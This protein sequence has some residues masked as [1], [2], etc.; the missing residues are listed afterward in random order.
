MA[1]QI[2]GTTVIDNSRNLSNIANGTSANTA[3]AFVQR[4]VSGNFSAGT[5]TAAL[6]GNSSTATTLQTARSINGVSFNGSADIVVN[7][8]TGAYSN[9]Q[10]AKTIQSGGSA[11]GGSSGDIYYIY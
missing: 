3:S 7:P 10:G 1:I 8:T 9:G 6:S 11:S 5:I 2:S 4:D